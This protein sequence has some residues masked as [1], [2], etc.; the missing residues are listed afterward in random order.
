[1]SDEDKPTPDEATTPT[2][3]APAPGWKQAEHRIEGG[4]Q[5]RDPMTAQ[6]GDAI[7]RASHGWL[8]DR[9]HLDEDAAGDLHVPEPQRWPDL[10][11]R[12]EDFVKGLMQGFIQKTPEEK[13]AAMGLRDASDVPRGTEVIG[14]L[15]SRFSNTVTDTWKEFV[16][17]HADRKSP[18]G[19]K[20]VD[21]EFVVQHGATLLGT[22]ITRLGEAFQGVGEAGGPEVGPDF[23]GGPTAAADE[24]SAAPGGETTGPA[25]TA[26]AATVTDAGPG[27]GRASDVQVDVDLGSIFRALFSPRP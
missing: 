1:M 18:E 11:T 15:L 5:P 7:T 21:G 13:E 3:E 12:A 16:D 20:V 8:R 2:P 10:G 6:L 17:E 27:E 25:A 4:E 19:K 24:A 9:F 22:M 23:A 26:E 14:R